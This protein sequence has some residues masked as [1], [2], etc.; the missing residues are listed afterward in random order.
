L[1]SKKEA[2]SNASMNNVCGSFR[3]LPLS[4][5]AI[6]PQGS[7]RLPAKVPLG[8]RFRFAAVPALADQI[9]SKRLLRL[10]ANCSRHSGAPEPTNRFIREVSKI[11]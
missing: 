5:D 6:S 8:G 1:W 10:R 2:I 4:F 7:D 3:I 11:T 9:N